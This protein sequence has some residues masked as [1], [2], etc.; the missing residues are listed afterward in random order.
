MADAFSTQPGMRATEI[1]AAL[2]T[3]NEALPPSRQVR[4]RIGI[5]LGDLMVHGQDLLGV[6]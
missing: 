5:N 6:A 1:Q 4:F 2:R 3:H